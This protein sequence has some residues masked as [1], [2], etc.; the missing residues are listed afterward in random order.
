M[1]NDDPVQGA[2]NMNH[3]H[4]LW[5]LSLKTAFHLLL[6]SILWGQLA[7]AFAQSAAP[8]VLKPVLRHSFPHNSSHFTQGLF[9]HNH[10]LYESTGGY[11][12][13]V[14]A[15]KNPVSGRSILEKKL[16]ADFFGEGSTVAGENLYLLTWKNEKALILNPETL[17]EKGSFFYA[18]EGWGLTC[19]GKHLIRSDG[20]SFLHFHDL[21]GKLL[22][23]KKICSG[24]TPLTSINEL[25]WMPGEN[26]LLAN[27]WRS[28]LI[29]VI[30]VSRGKVL[31]WLDM[32]EF[33]PEGL[34]D[35][36]A[37]LNGIAL[38]PD[39][40]SFWVTGKNWPVI[41]V[42]DWPPEGLKNL[43]VTS[44]SEE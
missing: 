33:I 32:R 6:F 25:E 35:P 23:S 21:E 34:K 22:F 11:G 27:I 30:D 38:S 9:F 28:P 18:G 31:A 20:S 12:K 3:K 7:G 14:M 2:K 36:E 17:E 15:V 42:L 4:A 5:T 13:S 16:N 41:H 43:I 29:A 37:V 24:S 8:P 44:S 19:D 40:R 10:L 26:L 39:G 1:N